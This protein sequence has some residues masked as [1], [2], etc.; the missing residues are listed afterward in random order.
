M[1]LSASSEYFIEKLAYQSTE[2]DILASFMGSMQTH[3]SRQAIFQI[4]FPGIYLED[5]SQYWFFGDQG[6]LQAHDHNEKIR[7]Q[8]LKYSEILGRSKFALC[9][10]GKS[11]SSFRLYEALMG[12]CVPVIIADEWIPPEGPNWQEFCLFVPENNIS[13][14]GEILPAWEA[15]YTKMSRL[16]QIAYQQWFAPDVRFHHMIESCTQILQSTRWPEFIW[17]KIPCQVYSK[18]KMFSLMKRLIGK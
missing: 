5:T 2:R 18:R 11:P 13:Q 3:S 17:Q 12:G 8:K 16:G 10:R 14:I 6:N 4:D 9:P 1:S 7:Q 15:E